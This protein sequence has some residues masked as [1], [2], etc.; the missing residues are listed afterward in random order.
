MLTHFVEM[1][2]KK[3]E[4]RYGYDASYLREVLKTSS[5][6]FFKFNQFV[7]LS[8]YRKKTPREVFY[9]AKM[10]ALRHGDC[11]PCLQLTVNFAL[12]EAVDPQLIDRALKAPQTLSPDQKLGYD[13]GFAVASHAE[14]YEE[15]SEQFEKKFGRDALV[16]TAMAV[17]TSLV[18][19]TLKRGL[20]LAKACHLVQVKVPGFDGNSK[21]HSSIHLT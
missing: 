10:A 8:K 9:L 7:G 11:G 6:L 3:F 19:P 2:I 14:N 17:A 21:Q 18:Y 4:N 5:S 15:L 16:E 13:F 20:R 1:G 12:E